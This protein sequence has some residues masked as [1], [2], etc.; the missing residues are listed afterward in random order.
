MTG[1]KAQLYNGI[2]LIGMFFSCR[3][4]WGTVQSGWVYYDMWRAVTRGPTVPF[5]AETPTNAS[6][7]AYGVEDVMYFAKDAVPIPIWLAAIYIT[8]NIT[9]HSLNVYWFFK[10]ISAVHKRFEPT[11][12]EVGKKDTIAA[13]ATTAA[14]IG[15]DRLDELRKRHIPDIVPTIEDD[16]SDIHI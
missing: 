7:V 11:A 16:L 2:A 1:S 8:A 10:M 3:L 4:A 12:K 5:A 9:L 13:S 14:K 15:I 6:A